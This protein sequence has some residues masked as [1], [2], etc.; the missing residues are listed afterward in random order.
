MTRDEFLNALCVEALRVTPEMT[1]S[2]LDFIRAH[3]DLIYDPALEDED[4]MQI[5][6][7]VRAFTR[8]AEALEN[9]VENG[10]LKLRD[11]DYGHQRIKP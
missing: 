6:Y 10:L 3:G 4:R 2:L 8:A 9:F 11:V 1:P 7:A 5:H